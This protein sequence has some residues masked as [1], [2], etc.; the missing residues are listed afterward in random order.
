MVGHRQATSAQ[1]SAQSSE[2]YEVGQSLT[3]ESQVCVGDGKIDEF[4]EIPDPVSDR[5]Q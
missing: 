2:F 4:T 1:R 5:L 3:F